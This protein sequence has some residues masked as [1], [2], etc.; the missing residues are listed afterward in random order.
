MRR[1]PYTMAFHAYMFIL[2]KQPNCLRQFPSA[3]AL[4]HRRALAPACLD[5]PPF[6]DIATF[7]PLSIFKHD[8]RRLANPRTDPSHRRQCLSRRPPPSPAAQRPQ[9]SAPAFTSTFT[10]LPAAAGSRNCLQIT[11]F[12]SL[13]EIRRN[14]RSGRRQ[15]GI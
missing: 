11:R 10:A 12:T 15:R 8:V 2:C 1:Y 3:S 6:S 4:R 7:P 13:R 9:T 14:S 5:C